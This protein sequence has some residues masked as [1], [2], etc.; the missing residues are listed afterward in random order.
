MVFIWGMITAFIGAPKIKCEQKGFCLI[1]KG[2][3]HM[4]ST[5]HR[6]ISKFL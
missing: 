3:R 2:R 6:Y 5:N 4:I 1:F